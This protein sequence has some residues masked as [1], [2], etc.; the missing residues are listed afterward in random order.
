MSQEINEFLQEQLKKEIDEKQLIGALKSGSMTVR[1]IAESFQVPIQTVTDTIQRLTDQKVMFQFEGDEVYVQESPSIGGR[2]M[3]NPEMWEGDIIRFGFCS[4]AHLGSHFERLD[5]LNLLYDLYEREGIK[6]V[7]NG[8]NWIEGEARFNKNE[9][10]KHGFGRQIAYAVQEYPYREGIET[11][12]VSGD[13]HEGWYNQREG[14]NSG[15]YFQME[16]ERA[17]KF[18]LK[19]LGYVEADIDLNHGEFEHSLWARLMHPGGGS[20]YALSYAPQKIIESLQGGEKPNVLFLGHYHKLSYD[21]IRNVHVVQMGTTC[22]QSI[23]MR[24]KKIEAHVGGGIAE[25]RRSPDGTLNRAKVEFI[26]AYDKKFYTG[27]DKY[28]KG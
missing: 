14:I 2:K 23:F 15:E 4:D 26:T 1:D 7:L 10:H 20:A 5:V 21:I 8:G 22:D 13:D 12:F 28:W 17:G 24:K 18:D 6:I 9:I 3:L 16:R 25:F 11:W 19:H 27:K